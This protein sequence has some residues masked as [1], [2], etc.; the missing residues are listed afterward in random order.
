M[1]GESYAQPAVTGWTERVSVHISSATLAGGEQGPQIRWPTLLERDSQRAL[2]IPMPKSLSAEPGLFYA[3]ASADIMIGANDSQMGCRITK[4]II[5]RPP[6]GTKQAEIPIMLDLCNDL[7]RYLRFRH[8]VN[9]DGR[10]VASIAGV[11]IFFS[12]R[13]NI[14]LPPP[15]FSPSKTAGHVLNE[16]GFWMDNAWYLDRF[17]LPAP[18]WPVD[19]LDRSRLPDAGRVGV[20]LKL[21]AKMGFGMIDGCKVV[22]SSGDEVVDGAICKALSDNGYKERGGGPTVYN[23]ED[24]YP[25]IVEWHGGRATI[26]APALPV[27]PHMPEDVIL[28]SG[29]RPVDPAPQLRAIPINVD[30]DSEGH[31]VGCKVLKT[32]GN[33][34][35]DAAG[36]RAVLRRGR[37][38]ISRDWFGRP[39]KG[40]YEAIADW[41]AMV[42]RP[43]E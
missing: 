36:C 38:T 31:P 37:F 16:Q 39:A 4:A 40:L 29:D 2:A 42:I 26:I 11:S 18:K 15:V 8:A 28:K 17:V 22:T 21:V 35:W 20:M 33:D 27:V 1:T 9:V 6:F 3:N 43:S 14:R 41:D 25:V 10:P 30:L 5:S 7:K 13:D 32:S 23:S 19:G 34:A 24:S 12:R